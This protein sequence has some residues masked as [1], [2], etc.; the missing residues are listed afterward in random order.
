MGCPSPSPARVTCL[1]TIPW[2]KKTVFY[3]TTCLEGTATGTVAN[4]GNGTI[5]GQMASLISEAGNEK[6]P[7]ASEIEHLACIVAGIHRHPF[8]YHQCPRSIMH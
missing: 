1:M 5:I 4:T 2:K 8:L 7:I 6:T 3:S